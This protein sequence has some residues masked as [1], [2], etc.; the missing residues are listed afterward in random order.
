VI[1]EVFNRQNEV[2]EKKGNKLLDF[3]GWFFVCHQKHKKMIIICTSYM[4]Y[5]QFMN[6]VKKFKITNDF[7]FAF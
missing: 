6:L 1:L 7:Y 5:T 2:K 3:Y 4:V